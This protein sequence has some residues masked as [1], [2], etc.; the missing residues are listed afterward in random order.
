MLGPCYMEEEG[1]RGLGTGEAP[2]GAR[3]A[4]RAL[5]GA[6]SALPDVKPPQNLSVGAM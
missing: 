5:P 1:G 4:R 6:P 3:G 2:G